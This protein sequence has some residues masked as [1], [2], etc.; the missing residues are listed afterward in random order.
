MPREFT[1][2]VRNVACK[3]QV[4]SK[5][6]QLRQADLSHTRLKWAAVKERGTQSAASVIMEK[7]I[8]PL[9]WYQKTGKLI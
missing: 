6:R 3:S 5:Y 8:I 7:E 2:P 4:K 1:I 9:K